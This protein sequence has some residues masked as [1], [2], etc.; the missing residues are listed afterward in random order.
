MRLT[1]EGNT[2]TIR[3]F[4]FVLALHQPSLVSSSSSS[5]VIYFLF[6]IADHFESVCRESSVS[7][8]GPIWFGHRIVVTSI[9][10]FYLVVNFVFMH[11]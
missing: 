10:F 5:S 2:N 11:R 9:S 3:L 1:G 4:I 6:F 7:R 8:N